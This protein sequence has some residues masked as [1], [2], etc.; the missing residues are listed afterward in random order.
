MPTTSR[1]PTPAQACRGP[2]AASAARRPTTASRSPVRVAFTFVDHEV[3]TDVGST[4]ELKSNEDLEV[5]ALIS[6]K[7]TLGAESNAEPQEGEASAGTMVS[8]AVNVAILNNTAQA[9]V[10]SRRPARRPARHAR[11]Q[12]RQLPV[13]AAPGRVHPAELGRVRSTASA[14]TAS[15]AVT[16]YLNTNLGFKDS[17]FNTWVAST[18]KAEKL[19]IAGVDQRAGP[20]Q[21]SPR[22][23]SSPTSR[24]T[25]TTPGTTRTTT[26]PAP[27]RTRTP[28]RRS[29]APT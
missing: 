25:R 15:S 2:R 4:A 24:S 11:H 23:W 16:K 21:R 14:T 17:F 18:A 28:T 13:P 1:R 10:H 12:R 26:P 19:G 29:T 5:K 20:E 27:R 6:Q 7:Y 22:P 3:L 8:L 9:T